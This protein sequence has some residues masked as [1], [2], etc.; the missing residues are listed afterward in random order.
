MGSGASKKDTAASSATTSSESSDAEDEY[1]SR[2]TGNNGIKKKSTL[3]P[4]NG[5]GDGGNGKSKKLSKS[6]NRSDAIVG[7][8][9]SDTEATSPRRKLKASPA[10]RLQQQDTELTNEI[11]DLE[12]TLTSMGLKDDDGG[13]RR[14][15]REKS[16]EETFYDYAKRRPKRTADLSRSMSNKNYYGNRT[17]NKL[18]FSWDD[19]RNPGASMSSNYPDKE[20]EEWTYKKVTFNAMVSKRGHTVA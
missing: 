8:D 6:L 2:F 18:K 20:S 9:D 13:S 4:L 5:I 15:P 19:D 17:N 10:R 1:T 3:K 7:Y 16:S 11:Q 14:N 12:N